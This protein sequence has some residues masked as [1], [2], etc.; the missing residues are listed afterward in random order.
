[1]AQDQGQDQDPIQWQDC[2]YLLTV[3]QPAMFTSGISVQFICTKLAAA[4]MLANSDTITFDIDKSAC[5]LNWCS[6]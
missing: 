5:G 4:W 1:L 3:P 2:I 6:Q